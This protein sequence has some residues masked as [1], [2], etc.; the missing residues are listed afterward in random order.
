M[1]VAEGR[2]LART[3]DINPEIVHNKT[4][5]LVGFTASTAD[6]ESIEVSFTVEAPVE[7]TELAV[8]EAMLLAALALAMQRN[9]VLRIRGKVSRSL[10][11]TV[12]LYQIAC[13]C[14]W[15]HRYRMVPIEVDVVDDQVP[16]TTRGVLCFSGGLDSIYS[17]KD[18]KA[19]QQV[20]SGLL[21][22]GYDID[23][24]EGQDQQRVRVARLLERL[25]LAMI[26]VK[27]NV[28]QALGQKVIEGAQ[29]SYLASALTLLSDSF[30]RGFVSSG[31]VDLADLGASDPVHEAVMPLL[32][33]S[34]Y[35]IVVYGGQI[36][37]MDKLAKIAA[38][39]A[40]I[41]DVRV[42]LERADDGHC[43]RCPKCLLNALASLAITGQWP[44]WYPEGLFDVRHLD[45]MPL[46]ETRRRYGLNI[47]RLAASRG[48]RGEWLDALQ[49][50]LT[51]KPQHDT[52]KNSIRVRPRD[53]GATVPARSLEKKSLPPHLQSTERSR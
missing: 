33:S 4:A 30:G 44:A 41:Q 22:A 12:D 42:C 8:T 46:N 9:S 45:A 32:G 40:L 35:P 5:T 3:I 49:A 27:T 19:A 48:L 52:V 53:D 2:N 39:P 1:A 34:R 47:V 24:G 17:A 31:L 7:P 20:D 11:H 36:P 26:V 15:P 37:R 51:I 38:E 29:G 25:G 10:R 6:G 18:L 43:G 14:W 16:H 13:A 50:H 23:P 28:R 21:I